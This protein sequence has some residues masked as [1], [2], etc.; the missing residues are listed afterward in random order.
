M[1]NPEEQERL[2]EKW[3]QAS[4]AKRCPSCRVWIQKTTGCNHISCRCGAHVCWTCLASFSTSDGTYAHLRE[5]HRGAN[6]ENV[7]QAQGEAARLQADFEY[8]QRLQLEEEGVVNAPAEPVVEELPQDD[9]RVRE[10]RVA[11]QAREDFFAWARARERERR[12]A[13]VG[14][15]IM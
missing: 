1:D 14:C 3:A 13:K 11:R 4:G 7:Q 8:A 5:T 12:R 2:N 9:M 6:Q 15:I 10:E